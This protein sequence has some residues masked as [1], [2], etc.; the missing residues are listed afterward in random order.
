VVIDDGDVLGVGSRPNEDDAPLLVDS[1]GV[2]LFE[3]PAKS[4]KVIRRGLT[5]VVKRYSSVDLHQT[6]Q[7]ALLNVRVELPDPAPFE[8]ALC[9]LVPEALDHAL[10]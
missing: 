6:T 4:L 3:V 8:K 2:I 10:K 9:L 5:E 1:D 7:G